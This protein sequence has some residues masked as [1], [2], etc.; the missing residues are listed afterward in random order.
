[1]AICE[2][3]KLPSSTEHARERERQ[4]DGAR[5]GTVVGEKRDR[6]E[7]THEHRKEARRG[8]ELPRTHLDAYVFLEHGPGARQKALR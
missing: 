8:N 2:Q 3:S 6:R 7:H 4:P 1:M 5:R